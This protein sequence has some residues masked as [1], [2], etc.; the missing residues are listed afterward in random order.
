MLFF[1]KVNM[2]SMA[3]INEPPAMN[4]RV[5]LSV[6]Q[7]PLRLIFNQITR[8][9]GIYFMIAEDQLD[10]NE[11]HTVKVKNET[12]QKL[13][14]LL[15]SKKGF[16]WIADGDIITFFKSSEIRQSNNPSA[17]NVAG[18]EKKLIIRGQVTD[19]AG[20]P[21]DGATVILSGTSTGSATDQLGRFTLTYKEITRP[22]LMISYTGYIRQEISVK[23]ADSIR[24]R[25]IRATNTLDEMVAIAYGS[26]SRRLNTGS[27]SKISD[28]EIGHQPVTNVLAALQGRIPGLTVTQ[29]SGVAG[30]SFTTQIRGRN[31]LVNGSEPL[32]I[33][34][35]VPIAP[36]NKKIDQLSS[37]ATQNYDL[38][39][40]SP[41]NSINP[42]DIASIEV[43][44]DAD[45]TAIYGSRGAN[46]V[47]LITTKRGKAGE[48]VFS[49]NVSTGISMVAHMEPLLSTQQYLGMRKEA[50]AN[51]GIIP[52]SVP[53]NTGYAP[54]LMLW[55]QQRSV[56]W[57]KFLIGGTAHTLETN[58][59]VSGGTAN[60]Q[61]FGSAGYHRETSVFPA[62]MAYNRGTLN[63]T[64][65]HKSAD[66]RF[67]V[68]FNAKY[69]ADKNHLYQTTF[70]SLFLAPN[71][72]AL[73]DSAGNLNWEEQGVTFDNPLADFLRK[74]EIQ[75][76]N[77]LSNLKL[78]YKLMDG[79]TVRSSVGLNW[80]KTKE[81]SQEPQAAQNP[82]LN[83]SATGAASF[84]TGNIKSYI[85][86]PQLDYSRTF[87]IGKI[88]ALL[89]GSW[90]YSTNYSTN[91]VATGYNNDA[92]LSSL[93][94]AGMI[95]SRTYDY[96][97]Y[98]YAAL[99][100]RLIYNYKDKYIV[101]ASARRD[102]SSR[103]GP[104]KRYNNFGA[105]GAAWIFTNESSEKHLFTF[106]DFGKLR[107]SYGITGNDQIGDY[108]Y[109][110]TWS[111]TGVPPYQG[112]PSLQPD[113]LFNNVF[114]WERNK[115]LEIAVELGAFHNRLFMS[116]DYFNNRSDNQLV[117]YKLPIQT[118]FMDIV[119]NI[120]A[121][122]ENA[123]WEFDATAEIIKGSGLNWNLTGN[124][125]I[126]SNKLMRYPN[127]ENSTYSSFYSVGYSVNLIKKYHSLGVDKNSGLFTLD[128]VDKNG[129][130]TAADY[131]VLG[132]LDPKYYGGI[133]NSFRL[134][135]FQLDFFL[136]FKNQT[137]P[138]YFYS[139]YV[140]GQTP[141]FAYNQATMVLD[142]W[143]KSG[144]IAGI[145]KFTS[146]TN[147][148]A[149][150][151][152]GDVAYSD[153]VYTSGAYIKLKNVS[154][155]YSMKKNRADKLKLKQLRIYI[156]GQNLFTFTKYKGFDPE[157]PYYFSLPPLRTIRAGLQIGL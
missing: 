120:P 100:G 65:N 99:F 1:L 14:S 13:L 32:F 19:D 8:Q 107:A 26:T 36:S 81:N 122:I 67:N 136:E 113:A 85:I 127:I 27:I 30:T 64:L 119:K 90:Q 130:L 7:Q 126:P 156:Q 92:L 52:S 143:Q 42:A 45:A 111:S 101:N 131:K 35:G 82:V 54:D 96:V 38:G 112:M 80:L 137:V 106:L 155:T 153:A 98:K 60:T 157:T 39:G 9:T 29:S 69:A 33:I 15:M 73:H 95:T 129:S 138:D 103:F 25:L 117:E 23:I 146:S 154:L 68:D 48:T 114:S 128:D 109:L 40:I 121:L 132:N 123:G 78:G 59:S 10:M 46:G 105:V 18:S 70:L 72:P 63:F 37:I 49:A 28:I 133:N 140:N 53:G 152:Q 89:G 44:K 16:N 88:S 5:T 87:S 6:V 43:L 141:G 134:H 21:L 91:I 79:L 62:E 86:E 148:A 2:I 104:G 47:I 149:Y 24:V 22:V 75:T 102:G 66:K 115:K 76:D 58:G 94:G 150:A 145:Q 125:T 12:I 34:D 83:P 139:V 50:F 56:D 57:Q 151:K 51:D 4:T 144:D 74:Y 17:G 55:D 93:D 97:K 142:R 110:N 135:E 3:Q 31:S 124:L 41:F 116:I 147:S 108:R 77:V 20:K 11:L 61:F 71:A 84:A 118:G